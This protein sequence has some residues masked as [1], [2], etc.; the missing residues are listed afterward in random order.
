MNHVL[1]LSILTLKKQFIDLI[2]S[3]IKRMLL[4]NIK[5]FYSFGILMLCFYQLLQL[6]WPPNIHLDK[7][8]NVCPILD[9]TKPNC[10]CSNFPLPGK[11]LIDLAD[12][13]VPETQTTANHSLNSNDDFEDQFDQVLHVD[14]G[15][16]EEPS[17]EY[18]LSDEEPLTQEG[19]DNDVEQFAEIILMKGTTFHGHFQEALHACK[20]LMLDEHAR[21]LSLSPEPVNKRNENAIVVKALLG[22]WKPIGYI[23]APKVPK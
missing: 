21:E 10:N 7:N 14:V 3:F 11:V 15:D 18:E 9:I 6:H 8:R 5:K 4:V 16:T 22:V 17:A 2:F 1:Y 12:F 19:Q 13:V 23:P 20:Q